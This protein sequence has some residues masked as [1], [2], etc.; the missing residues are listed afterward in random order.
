MSE[1]LKQIA[2]ANKVVE[3]YVKSLNTLDVEPI[4][5]LLHPQFGF[6]YA[7]GYPARGLRNDWR[8]LGYMY[9]TF[10]QMKK[11]GLKIHAEKALLG[12]EDYTYPCVLLHPPH[13]RRIIFPNEELLIKNC[14]IETPQRE[15]FLRTRVKDGKI[16]RVEGLLHPSEYETLINSKLKF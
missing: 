6:R 4:T 10:A 8:Y 5:F 14:W 2:I 12:E 11:E 3:Q 13:D 1:I 15:I 16:F 9:Q 7:S